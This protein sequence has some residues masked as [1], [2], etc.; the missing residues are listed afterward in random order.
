MNVI[1]FLQSFQSEGLTSFF[2][3][4]TR[5]G[6][7]EGHLFGLPLIYWLWNKEKV[8][9]LIFLYFSASFI[10]NWI[11]DIF[12]AVRPEGVALI[13]QG[14]Y[15]FPSG[16]AAGA[17]LTFFMLM[18]LV[19]KKWMNIF[20]LVMIFLISLSRVYLGVHYLMDVIAGIL[21]GSFLVFI[22]HKFLF[23]KIKLIFSSKTN[24]TQLIML[25][26]IV[27]ALILIYHT[28]STIITLSIIYG[29]G[30]GLIFFY[31]ADVSLYSDLK[32]KSLTTVVGTMC[33]LPL[34]IA[35]K[36]GLPFTSITVFLFFFLNG[37]G[38]IILP[39][40]FRQRKT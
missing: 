14:G 39:F 34:W 6:G 32:R 29:F 11:K 12:E 20:G 18:L 23:D 3:F 10:I 7:W 30:I 37:F 1:N 13:E 24:I 31:P 35:M 27:F 21:I 5:I 8:T 19:R 26:T 4:I 28:M 16:H 15:S 9:K 25:T 38:I 33:L 17:T 22:Y 40:F 2:I 36:N